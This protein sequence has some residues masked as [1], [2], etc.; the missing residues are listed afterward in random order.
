MERIVLEARMS[1]GAVF[2]TI[3]SSLAYAERE[4]HIDQRIKEKDCLEAAWKEWWEDEF[5]GRYF[6]TMKSL[7]LI[8]DEKTI[9]ECTWDV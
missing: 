1:C 3:C 4:Y 9:Q 7:K 8:V 2:Q 5:F 6:S